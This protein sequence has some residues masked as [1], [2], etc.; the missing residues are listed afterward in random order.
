MKTLLHILRTTFKYWLLVTILIVG[1][2]FSMYAAMQQ[3]LRQGA[4][5]PQIQMAED[6]AA[7]LAAGQSIQD[8]IPAEKVNIATS[9]APYMIIFDAKGIPIASSAQL[10]GQTPTIPSGVFD[11][12]QKNGEDRITWQP[13]DGVRSAVIV[14]QFKGSSTG[15]VLAGR[16]LREVEKREDNILLLLNVGWIG[17]LIITLPITALVFR[18]MNKDQ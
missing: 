18:K 4:D 15:F 11:Y 7:K 5:D 9:I 10:N 3:I 17:M 13:Q 6:A 12:V 8:V 16:S 2:Y 1:F 14:T